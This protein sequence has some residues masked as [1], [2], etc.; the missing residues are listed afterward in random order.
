MN[1]F[2]CVSPGLEETLTTFSLPRAHRQQ[3]VGQGQNLKFTCFV[4]DQPLAD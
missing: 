1:L 3:E 2:S 4:Y